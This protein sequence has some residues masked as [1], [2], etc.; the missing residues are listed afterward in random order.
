MNLEMRQAFKKAVEEHP[1]LFDDG[2][3][4][5][6]RHRKAVGEAYEEVRLAE[7][8]PRTVDEGSETLRAAFV[9]VLDAEIAIRE[10]LNE[11]VR[12]PQ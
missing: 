5:M 6:Y 4:K 11:Q 3:V 10:W 2:V 9:K 8:S 1:E 7:G 12:V